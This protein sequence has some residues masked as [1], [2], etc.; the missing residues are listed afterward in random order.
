DGRTLL[1]G[2]W[3]HSGQLFFSL[4][5]LLRGSSLLVRRGFDAAELV[6]LIDRERVTHTHLVPIHFIRLLRLPDAARAALR[7]DTLRVVW[8]GAAACPVDVK[9]AMIDWWGPAFTEYYAATE[10]GIAT[11]IDSAQWLE[12]PGSVGRSQPPTEIVIVGPDGETLPPHTD[13]M[14]YLRRPPERGFK[15]HNAPEKTRTA[16]L[17]DRTFTYG[18]IGHLDADGY[19]Y[20][21]GR[22]TDMVITGGVN[23]YPAEVESVLLSHPAVR[24]AAVFGVPDP[25]YGERVTAAVVVGPDAGEDIA[26]VLDRHCRT[27]LAGFKVPRRYKLVADLPR[28]PSGKLRKHLLTDEHAPA[29]VG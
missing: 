22:A 7:G 24:D 20:L 2:P 14:I 25:E 5:P 11:V 16:Y 10:G 21:T 28:D 23:V 15:Y 6:E 1:V 12:H 18:D 19:L 26:E 29:P 3:Y 17:D 8:H 4:F 9:R 27:Q 13:G